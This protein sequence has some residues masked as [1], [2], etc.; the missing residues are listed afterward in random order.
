[1]YLFPNDK[2]LVKNE[3]FKF[4]IIEQNNLTKGNL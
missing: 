1:M 2:Y 3:G 4:W